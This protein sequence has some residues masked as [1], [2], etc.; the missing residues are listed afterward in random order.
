MKK[1]F[2][3]LV[4]LTFVMSVSAQLTVKQVLEKSDKAVSLKAGIKGKLTMKSAGKGGTYDFATDGLTLYNAHE[5]GSS[6]VSKN[7][8]YKIDEKGKTLTIKDGRKDFLY[9]NPVGIAPMLLDAERIKE[10]EVTD[11][12]MKTEKTQYVITYKTCGLPMELDIDKKTF[13]PVR[14]KM[15]KGLF[16]MTSSCSNLTRLTDKSLLNFDK[17]KYSKY[18]VIDER[19][20]EKKK[21]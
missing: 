13:M 10:E 16:T 4:M 5:E 17:S 9:L 11:L 14:L 12:K 1:I 3:L 20:K 8:V 15:G 19:G 7:I 2:T 18:K 6:W 21:K